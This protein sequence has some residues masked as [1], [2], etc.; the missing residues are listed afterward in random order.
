M[1]RHS[2]PVIWLPWSRVCGRWTA[3]MIGRQ[4][5]KNFHGDTLAL[6]EKW[7]KNE[8]DESKALQGDGDCDRTLLDA[9]ST[10]FGLRIAFDEATAERTKFVF[11]Q[12][13]HTLDFESHHTPPENFLR[14]VGICGAS[15]RRLRSEDQRRARRDVRC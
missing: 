7:D 6:A 4:R 12:S 10:H 9:A 1:T 2:Y 13:G 14:A 8:S 11:G 15:L 3:S 5:S